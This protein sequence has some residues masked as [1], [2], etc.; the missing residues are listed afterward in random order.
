MSLRRGRAVVLGTAVAAV[1][2][3]A[4]HAAPGASA[5]LWIVF[6]AQPNG[7]GAPQGSVVE[8]EQQ[9]LLLL[10]PERAAEPRLDPGAALPLNAKSRAFTSVVLQR[11]C[12]SDLSRTAPSLPQLRS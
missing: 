4:A 11:L 7:L 2:L 5:P 1:A 12:R 9:D 3:A 10:R 8:E 6:S